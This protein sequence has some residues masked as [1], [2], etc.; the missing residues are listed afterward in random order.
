MRVDTERLAR[1]R[2]A[3]QKA[4]IDV[5]VCR[6]PENVVMLT[7]YWPMNGFAFLVFPVEK[8]PL[9]IAPLPEDELAREGWVE[10]VRFFPWGLVD[11]GDPFETVA[12]LLKQAA[13]DQQ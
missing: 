5:L 10:D 3:L 4:E 13:I 9:L 12:Q 6:L 11:S 2:R 1:A 8:D 7:G